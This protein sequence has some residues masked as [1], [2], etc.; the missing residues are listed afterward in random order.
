LAISLQNLEAE[1]MVQRLGTHCQAE[2]LFWIPQHDGWISTV[3][4]GETIRGYAAK[5]VS[6]AVGFSPVFTIKSLNGSKTP[7]GMVH[8]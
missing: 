4:D 6:G 1:L 3:G 2:G 7:L 8:S 5:I